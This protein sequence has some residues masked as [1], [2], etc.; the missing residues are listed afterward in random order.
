MTF[1]QPI[2]VIEKEFV[3]LYKAYVLVVWYTKEIFSY[4][5]MYVDK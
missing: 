2:E 4:H 3:C 5:F 1:T